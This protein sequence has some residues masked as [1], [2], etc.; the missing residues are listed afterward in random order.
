MSVFDDV[1]AEDES[2]SEVAG[3][4]H[5]QQFTDDEFNAI[6]E[7]VSSGDVDPQ[8]PLHSILREVRYQLRAQPPVQI[9]T[10]LGEFIDVGPASAA[11][12]TNFERPGTALVK[13]DPMHPIDG[14][15]T[16]II[17]EPLPE[18][19]SRLHRSGMMLAAAALVVV[20]MVAGAGISRSLAP[21]N[22]I[23]PV[24]VEGGPTGAESPAIFG[25]SPNSGN[26]EVPALVEPDAADEPAD[27][28]S[29]TLA[30]LADPVKPA[31]ESP[32][33]LDVKLVADEEEIT[34]D[35][36]DASNDS[37]I[38][39]SVDTA[40]RDDRASVAEP[41]VATP[42]VVP[43]TA[44]PEP[45]AIPE[46]TA[47]PAEPIIVPTSTPTPSPTAVPPTSTPAPRATAVPPTSTPVPTA[48]AV[49]TSTPRPTATATPIPPTS[50]PAPTATST[51]T[52]TPEP[53]STPS[54]TATPTATPTPLPDD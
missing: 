7:R 12:Y 17:L 18:P 38:D 45:T 54:P 37:L 42:T 25:S 33:S 40:A 1:P 15:I 36:S 21:N 3:A 20:A 46:Q 35:E 34:P 11:R 5:E 23:L 43:P 9:G 4:M 10:E 14:G 51:P 53:T 13:Y 39:D 6:V 2:F 31:A 52:P 48:T 28:D 22:T 47:P 49:P 30:D 19:V 24:D 32:D 41:T 8:N 44:T 50:T 27:A 16:D 29:D 26:L